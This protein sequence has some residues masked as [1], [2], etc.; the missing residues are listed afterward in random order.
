MV[1]I[2]DHVSLSRFAADLIEHLMLFVGGTGSCADCVPV[3]IV[4]VVVVVIVV[5]AVVIIII[6]IIVFVV[7]P[8]RR[9]WLVKIEQYKCFITTNIIV[10]S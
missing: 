4:V 7:R 10:C 1:R 2:V 3:P 5:V 6:I 8:R 9:S